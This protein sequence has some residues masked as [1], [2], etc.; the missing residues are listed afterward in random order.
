MLQ[1]PAQAGSG[2]PTGRL[3]RQTLRHL[4]VPISISLS[5]ANGPGYELWYLDQAFGNGVLRHIYR[6]LH[7]IPLCSGEALVGSV[8][9]AGPFSAMH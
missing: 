8:I 3:G 1:V 9:S 4:R 5:G 2:N 6:W 7:R